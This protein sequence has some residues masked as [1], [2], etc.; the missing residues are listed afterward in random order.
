L[1][2]KQHENKTFHD[3]RDLLEDFEIKSNLSSCQSEILESQRRK[4]KV[5]KARLRN[6]LKGSEGEASSIVRN[7]PWSC[8]RSI[9]MVSKQWMKTN[10]LKHLFQQVLTE[11]DGYKMSTSKTK[12]R[13]SSEAEVQT[14]K[15]LSMASLPQLSLCRKNGKVVYKNG[16]SDEILRK[17]HQSLNKSENTAFR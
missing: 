16:P 3:V 15:S 4:K 6:I 11:D 8:N 12:V 13:K 9:S 2:P 7:D 14:Q 1:Q 10:I 5:R 17:H